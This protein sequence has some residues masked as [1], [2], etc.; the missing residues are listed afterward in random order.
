MAF[1]DASKKSSGPERA[2]FK[3]QA[4]SYLAMHTTVFGKAPRKMFKEIFL[5]TAAPGTKL[6][7]SA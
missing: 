5:D 2:A 6:D 7:C 3:T 4:A 1:H